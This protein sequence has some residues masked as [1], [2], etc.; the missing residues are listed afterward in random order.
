MPAAIETV[1]GISAF[2]SFREP[3]W[4]NLGTVTN[5]ELSPHDFLAV[6]KLNGW[7]VRAIDVAP[8]MPPSVDGSG[9]TERVIIRNNPFFNPDLDEGDNNPR[10]NALGIVGDRYHIAQNEELADFGALID[11]RPETAGSLFGGK[12]VFMSFALKKRVVIDPEGVADVVDLY[13]LTY[14]SHNGSSNFVVAMTP[15]RVVCAN[16]LRIAQDSMDPV[17]KVRHSK[18]MADRLKA[19]K[20]ALELQVQYTEEFARR[21]ADLHEAAV[22]DQEFYDIV[23]LLYPLDDNASKAA[24]TRHANKMDSIMGYWGGATQEGI[25]NTG[26]GVLNTLTE[27]QQ[28]GRAVYGGNLENFNAA[29][30][31]FNDLVNKERDKIFDLVTSSV[32][33]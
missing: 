4:H 6:A 29:G 20:D 32:L 8:L 5:D 14:T 28:W 27:H 1:N 9:L 10:V 3:A 24:V 33:V 19:A 11:A 16:T 13:L 15:V 30:A 22:T 23:D 18:S 17:L 21:A 25:K 7:D 31:G 12:Q 2:A 26:W